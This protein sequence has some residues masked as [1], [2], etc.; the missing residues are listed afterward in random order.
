MK[1]SATA[2]H[3]RVSGDQAPPGPSNSGGG[4]DSSVGNPDELTATE[5]VAEPL[6]E[7]L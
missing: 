6:A 5:P 1:Q 2:A 4:A 3:S 7:A